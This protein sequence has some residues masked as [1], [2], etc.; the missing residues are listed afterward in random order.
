MHFY[1]S[2]LMYFHCILWISLLCL[3]IFSKNL[4]LFIIYVIIPF[5]YMIHIFPF[6]FIVKM[7]INYI[8]DN[9]E[10][11]KEYSNKD[12]RPCNKEEENDLLE[13]SKHM[14]ISYDNILL[15]FSVYDHYEDQMS[16][17][18]KKLRT[19]FD[20]LSSFKNPAS[21]Q[22]LMI[23]CFITNLFYLKF[24]HKLF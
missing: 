8:I 24:I 13:L 3:G 20:E 9:W 21:T 17:M 23:L 11:L 6:H 7:K 4:C 19:K 5:I 15:Y 22:G 1:L 12:F 10:S 18:Y 2:F 14:D 16:K